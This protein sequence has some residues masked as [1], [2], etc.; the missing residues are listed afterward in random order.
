VVGTD[1]EVTG[2]LGV[3]GIGLRLRAGNPENL[4]VVVAPT[5]AAALTPRRPRSTA[6][7]VRIV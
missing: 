7:T 3:D 5:R 4:E 1:L 6:V 2:T